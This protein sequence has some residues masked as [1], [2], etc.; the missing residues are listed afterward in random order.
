[1]YTP[2]DIAKYAKVCMTTVYHHIAKGFIQA[3]KN[4]QDW[5]VSEQEYAR[6]IQSYQARGFVLPAGYEGWRSVQELSKE[7]SKADSSIHRYLMRGYI[8]GALIKGMRRGGRWFIEPTAYNS[9]VQRYREAHQH[10]SQWATVNDYCKAIGLSQQW[11]RELIRAGRVEADKITRTE[12]MLVTKDEHT[13]R[14]PAHEMERARQVGK[15]VS[16]GELL[17]GIQVDGIRFSRNY[18]LYKVLPELGLGES[19]HPTRKARVSPEH[20]AKILDY[21][22]SEN[23][24]VRF[25]R[26]H[27]ASEAFNK[28]VMQQNLDSL[29][30]GVLHLFL[31]I[32]PLL[33]MKER[34]GYL[35]SRVIR[36]R[37]AS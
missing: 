33:N 10:L 26:T 2:K 19:E 28:Q 13:Y 30:L 17:S 16:I 4:A 21:V 27:K 15:L 25:N 11:V 31:T 9:F 32:L 35:L 1:M 24:T 12:A 6:V 5:Q 34:C 37:L 20:I 36:R 23:Q 22:S 7:I 14:I 29:V 8:R 18:F 3:K